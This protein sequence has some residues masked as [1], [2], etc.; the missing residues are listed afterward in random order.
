MGG[1]GGGG[2]GWPLW[3]SL[4]LRQWKLYSLTATAAKTVEI[5]EAD[6]KNENEER[7]LGYLGQ[8]VGSMTQ[9]KVKVSALH[10]WKLCV[11]V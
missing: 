1:G 4:F 9:D 6:G 3:P 5:M 7:V 10:H 11:L 2:G 8:Y